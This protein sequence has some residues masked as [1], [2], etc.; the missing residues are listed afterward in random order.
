VLSSNVPELIP[1][2]LYIAIKIPL[3]LETI[4]ILFI[5]LG[6]DLAPA[7]ALA[8]EEPEDAVMKVPPRKRDSHII[9]WKMMAVAYVHLGILLT[10]GCFFAYYWVYYAKGFTFDSLIGSGIEYRI[11][12]ADMTGG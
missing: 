9:S 5:D 11:P 1:F 12:Y 3:A 7:V 6:T 10:I 4:H 2:L 8:Y